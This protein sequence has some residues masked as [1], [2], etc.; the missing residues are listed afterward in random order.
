MVS[1]ELEREPEQEIGERR[2]V[3]ER[4][5]QPSLS[6]GGRNLRKH[7][8]LFILELTFGEKIGLLW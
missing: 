3:S 7:I 8:K 2:R 1:G 6:E 4:G 5:V